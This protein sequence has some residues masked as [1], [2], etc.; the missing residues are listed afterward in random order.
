[1]RKALVSLS[2]FLYGVCGYSQDIIIT[3]NQDTIGC[4]V[5]EV[6][7][8]S[9]KFKYPKEEVVTSFSN[10][11]IAKIIFAS[12]REQIISEKVI[13]NG[14]KDWEKVQVTNNESEI[15]GLVRIGEI[16]AKASGGF[17]FSNVGKMQK[18][19]LKQLKEEAADKGAHIVLI[20]LQTTKNGSYGI[21]GSPKASF[22]GV[23]YG[24]S[25]K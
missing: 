9:I 6:Q 17:T 3:H 24:Y 19:A 14:E 10:N 2:L 18:K 1:M 22:R 20:L 8:V 25:K 23:A 4:K 15:I 13:I 11:T 21:S 5:I 12:G 16:D 7:E